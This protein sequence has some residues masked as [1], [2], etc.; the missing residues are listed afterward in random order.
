[1]VMRSPTPESPKKV[2]GLAPSFTPNRTISYS[3]RVIKPDFVLSPN[4]SPSQTPAAIAITFFT[5][6]PISTPT[7]SFWM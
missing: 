6:P 2:F 3:P 7:T 5:A 1:V 4:L